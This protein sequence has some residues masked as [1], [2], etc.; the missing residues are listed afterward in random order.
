[1][2]KLVYGKEYGW[3]IPVE[4]DISKSGYSICRCRCGKFKSI[5]NDHILRNE[6]ISCGC[7]KPIAS[8][9]AGITKKKQKKYEN[10]SGRMF[11]KILVLT[12][13]EKRSKN[14][15]VVW[16]CVCTNCGKKIEASSNDLKHNGRISCGCLKM[17]KGEKYISDMLKNIGFSYQYDVPFHDSIISASN[18]PMRFD[19]V[20]NNEYV[21]EYDG[22]SHYL[23]NKNGY[24]DDEKLQKNKQ[25][26]R[27]KTVFCLN[28]K[29]PLIRIPFWELQNISARDLCINTSNYVVKSIDDCITECPSN[30]RRAFESNGK[31]VIETTGLIYRGKNYNECAIA[32]DKDLTKQPAKEKY[33]ESND[34]N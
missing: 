32:C 2:E 1:M 34:S 21:I 20:V 24:F 15:A 18:F 27:E 31:L 6:T 17:S 28:N 5:R 3:L 30:L 11:G 10:L 33:D 9:K 25:R 23:F 14:R 8:K 22:E 13:T 26:D 4:Q 29:I 19:F 7:Y 16:E 12:P